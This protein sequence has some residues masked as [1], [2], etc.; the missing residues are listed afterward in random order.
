MS[1]QTAA[2]VDIAPPI[3]Q[4][5]GPGSDNSPVQ[6]SKKSNGKEFTSN[7]NPPSKVPPSWLIVSASSVN[8]EAMALINKPIARTKPV[9]P[10]KKL[11][12]VSVIIPDDKRKTDS[13]P[14]TK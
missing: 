10:I 8:L 4:N 14:K 11:A 9:N 12:P 13:N 6:V 7:T 2:A 5:H 1:S 3:G